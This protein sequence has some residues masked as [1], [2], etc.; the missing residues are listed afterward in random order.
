MFILMMSG[1]DTLMWGNSNPSQFAIWSAE[2]D[3][4]KNAA[5]DAKTLA[6]QLR[7]LPG[8]SKWPSQKPLTSPKHVAPERAAK[9]WTQKGCEVDTP[10]ELDKACAEFAEGAAMGEMSEK[11]RPYVTLGQ[12]LGGLHPGSDIRD[13][14]GSRAFSSLVSAWNRTRDTRR[15]AKYKNQGVDLIKER[16]IFRLEGKREYPANDQKT[17]Y[18]ARV[19]TDAHLRCYAWKSRGVK[20]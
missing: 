17:T 1:R 16:Q 4:A 14:R 10:S 19:R 3:E 15:N 13:G 7:L 5:A 2:A 18:W 8:V 12:I 6:Q 11:G 9:Y 20:M